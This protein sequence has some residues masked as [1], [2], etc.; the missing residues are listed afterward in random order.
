MKEGAKVRYKKIFH[1][2]KNHRHLADLRV[3]VLR[4]GSFNSFMVCLGAST[5]RQ[6][7]LVLLAEEFS[8]TTLNGLYVSH[9]E[10]VTDFFFDIRHK[11]PKTTSHQY[12]KGFACDAAKGVFQGNIRVA[13]EATLTSSRQLNKNLLL[14]QHA[15]IYTKP[16]LEID[17]DD[18]KCSHGATVS[19]VREDELFYLQTR[20]L[21][22]EAAIS[23]LIVAFFAELL[24][25]EKQSDSDICEDEIKQTIREIIK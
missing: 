15:E 24:E 17:T 3:A 14:G 5:F 8:H 21:T 7:S 22:R 13:E 20:G 18:V 1:D 4:G 16:Q 6:D 11:A 25:I 9:G 23:F 2:A 10:N 19:Q 12:F